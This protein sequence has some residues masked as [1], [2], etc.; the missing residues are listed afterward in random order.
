MDGSTCTIFK[1][2]PQPPKILRR[3]Q[4]QWLWH[5]NLAVLACTQE[6]TTCTL[7]GQFKQGSS[8]K[9]LKAA[10][11]TMLRLIQ[12]KLIW[13]SYLTVLACRN[14]L[15]AH[16]MHGPVALIRAL[17][18]IKLRN[19]QKLRKHNKALKNISSNHFF[20]FRSDGQYSTHPGKIQK[21]AVPSADLEHC[22][23]KY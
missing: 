5:S 8:Y 2:S 4:N 19:P 20:N 18:E 21:I 16:Y 3:I 9:I 7:H 22:C 11:T 12:N 14:P 1:G 6:S 15:G 23:G 13:P 17:I 10:P